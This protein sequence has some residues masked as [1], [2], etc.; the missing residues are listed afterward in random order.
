[1]GKSTLLNAILG[2]KLSATSRRPQTTRHNIL[3]VKTLDHLQ[4]V[5]CDTPGMYHG[6]R[7][8]RRVRTARTQVDG[9]DVCLFV[10]DA[11]GFNDADRGVLNALTRG[12]SLPV[13]AVLNKID[14][15]P[16]REDL[17]PMLDALQAE[18]LFN[19]YFP[20]SAIR[21][22]DR[23]A[24]ESLEA[25]VA[26]YLPEGD[27]A[28]PAD[29]QTDCSPGF[30]VTEMIRE[31][32]MRQMGDELPYAVSV[33]LEHWELRNERTHIHACIRAPRLSHKKMLVGRDGARIK[34]IGIAARLDI[35][36]MLGTPV[37]LRLRVDT[38]GSL[39]ASRA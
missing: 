24:F 37:M 25:C 34:K 17:L 9:M 1:M 22:A 4:F 33:V 31:K 23:R 20:I 12:A 6:R 2:T 39:N 21:S 15:L 11:R 5:Y 36:K 26:A 14:L 18:N 8:D 29:Y 32:V 28:F 13:V 27:H 10:F 7:S 19:E 16:R 30:L 3:G 35:E 38:V